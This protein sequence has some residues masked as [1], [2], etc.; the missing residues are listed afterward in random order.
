MTRT[1]LLFGITLA[2]IGA[3]RPIA[4]LA[5]IPCRIV[6]FDKNMLG[7]FKLGSV[8]IMA[9]SKM[10]LANSPKI[11]HVNTDFFVLIIILFL[12]FKKLDYI[13]TTSL[14]ITIILYIFHIPPSLL[15]HVKTGKFIVLN[16]ILTKI[17]PI[18][19]YKLARLSLKV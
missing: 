2:C 9:L 4:D 1:V 14:F 12:I 17:S 7:L 18:C 3:V 19:Q 10:L 11:K 6:I 16:F 5:S 8:S 13:I 15:V